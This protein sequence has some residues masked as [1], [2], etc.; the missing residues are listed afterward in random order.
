V[1][2]A[3][4]LALDGWLTTDKFGARKRVIH[5]VP[6]GDQRVGIQVGQLSV[7]YLY[8]AKVPPPVHADAPS[9]GTCSRSLRQARWAHVY[10]V[11]SDSS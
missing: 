8:S 10:R 7:L 1:S 2:T 5:D 11:A 4:Y 9:I 3:E 6:R